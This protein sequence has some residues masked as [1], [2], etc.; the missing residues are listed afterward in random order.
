[1][2][3]KTRCFLGYAALF[4]V[5][6]A[7]FFSSDV[8]ARMRVCLVIIDGF[9]VAGERQHDVTVH[10]KYIGGLKRRWG[11]LR[12][13]AHGEYVGLPAGAAGNSEAGHSALGAG[14]R[15]PQALAQITLAVLQKAVAGIAW[16]PRVHLVGLLSDGGIH[17]HISH[18]RELCSLIPGEKLVHAIADGIDTPPGR[19]AGFVAEFGDSVV[20]VSGRYYAMDRDGNEDRIERAFEAMTD[21]GHRNSGFRGKEYVSSTW[22]G[23]CENRLSYGKKQA[24]T[25]SEKTCGG[26][27]GEEFTEPRRLRPFPIKKEDTVLFFNFREDRMRQLVARFSAFP[28]IYTMIDYG[29][30]VGRP[31][32]GTR[33]MSWTLPAVL[34]AGGMTQAH[35]A[36][37]EKYAHVTYFFAGGNEEPFPGEKRVLVRSPVVATFEEAP[38]TG[39]GKVAAET[40]LLLNHRRKMACSPGPHAAE[41][42]KPFDFVVA[43]LAGPDLLGH[44]GSIGGATAA[45]KAADRAVENIHHVCI[46]NDYVLIVTADHGNVEKMAQCSD[47]SHRPNKSHTTNSVPFIIAG[48]PVDLIDDAVHEL[49]DVAPTVLHLLGIDAPR[50]MTGQSLIKLRN[51]ACS[52]DRPGRRFLNIKK[53]F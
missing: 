39:M 17:S 31:L 48:A 35:I 32:V 16:T 18:V 27:V 28:N 43:N 40:M 47:G 41:E 13:H 2:F 6:H 14:R 11:W 46:A 34:S 15:V 8:Y 5:F 29:V 44:T 12:L 4:V 20:S 10:A 50:E 7:A 51:T 9:G 24:L 22:N 1:M 38:G 37:S 52:G 21:E 33:S 19:F 36:E 3:D 45:V 30:G 53:M 26:E 49:A 23:C 42:L 25:E